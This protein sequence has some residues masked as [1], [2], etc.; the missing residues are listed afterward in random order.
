L[1]VISAVSQ[2]KLLATLTPEDYRRIEPMLTRTPLPFKKVVHKH[3]QPI[4]DVYFPSS[5]VCSITKT[6]DDG[7]TAEITAIGNEGIVGVWALF[8]DLL[9]P[10]DAWMQIAGEDGFRMPIAA[11]KTEIQHGGAFA[12]LVMRYSQAL[13]MTTMQNT[14]CN[15]LHSAMQRCARW[16]LT[17]HDRVTSND[18]KLTHELMSI[19]LGVRRPTVTVVL[20]DLQKDG[21]IDVRRSHIHILDAQ[22]L[23][24][25][26][27]E[28]YQSA[29][30]NFNRL[31]PE[32]RY[33]RG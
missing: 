33:A 17:S 12:D 14:V 7:A 9:S 30:A 27:C 10:A 8:G 20:G 16:L 19:M 25:R 5:G 3:D 13:W 28:C 18:L 23:T 31:L 6:M 32:V 29:K 22:L 21:L 4:T 26:S 2:N 15:G 1:A 11:F 24:A